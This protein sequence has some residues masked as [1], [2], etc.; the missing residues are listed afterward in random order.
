MKGG[1]TP[2]DGGQT[3]LAASEGQPS[4][5]AN[6]RATAGGLCASC[7]AEGSVGSATVGRGT[8]TK[9]K[10]LV[11]DDDAESVKFVRWVLEGEGYAI[12]EAR[13]GRE[14]LI[15]SRNTAPT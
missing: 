9:K 5:R 15:S 7:L 6:S 1:G 13:S 4:S 2:H 14:C 11:V 12:L 3:P 8:V 10:I